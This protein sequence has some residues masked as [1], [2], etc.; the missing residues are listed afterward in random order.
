M[1]GLQLKME[2]FRSGGR[3]CMERARL[4]KTEAHAGETIEV[5]ATLH[6]YQAEAR[7]VRVR[8]AAAGG[9]KP[10]PLRI[11]VSDGATLDRLTERSGDSCAAARGGAGGYGGA[12]EPDAC[13]R[14]VYVTLLDQAAQAVLD[15]EALAEVPLSMAN[16]LEP[17]KAAQ[18]MQLTGESVVEAGSVGT[19]YAVRGSQVLNLLIR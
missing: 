15:A 19:Q 11:V 14:S 9:L 8:F 6:P 1:T 5:E 2:G 3:R 12:D 17:L 10:G 13:E 18:R 4:G 16:V 7:V